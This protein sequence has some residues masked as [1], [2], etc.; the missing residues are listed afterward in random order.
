M[1]NDHYRNKQYEAA[2]YAVINLAKQHSKQRA[3]AHDTPADEVHVLDIG[4]GSGLLGLLAARAGADRVTACEMVSH[5]LSIDSVSSV[6][7]HTFTFTLTIIYYAG[8]CHGAGRSHDG[9]E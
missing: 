1:L 7:L 9:T 4:T 5:T 8:A 6:I 3:S 2:L